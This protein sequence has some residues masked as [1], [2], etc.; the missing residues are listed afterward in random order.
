MKA[1]E[2]QLRDERVSRDTIRLL[3]SIPLRGEGSLAD[4]YTHLQ[5]TT[6]AL[7]AADSERQAAIAALRGPRVRN[8]RKRWALAVELIDRAMRAAASDPTPV[9]GAI[10]IAQARPSPHAPLEF[11]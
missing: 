8:A 5:T 1:G 7:S 6:E 9:L 4:T 2:R 10:R 3:R 11:T